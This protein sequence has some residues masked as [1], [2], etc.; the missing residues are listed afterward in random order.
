MI[1]QQVTSIGNKDDSKAFIFTLKN[2]YGVEP[3]RYM[4]RREGYAILCRTNWGPIF[5]CFDICIDNLCNK[6]DNCCINNDG[7]RGYE[8][9]SQYK[10]SLFVKTNKYNKK[11]M[12]SVL[13]YEVFTHL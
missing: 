8:C 1:L 5:G 2:P 3:T 12:L 4:K 13:D 9:H 7:T 11:N 10:S 6:E